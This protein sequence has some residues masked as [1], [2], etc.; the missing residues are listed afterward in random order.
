MMA[1][2]RIQVFIMVTPYLSPFM[3]PNSYK[4]APKSPIFLLHKGLLSDK[5]V[6]E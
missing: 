5:N 1:S 4:I 6:L 3:Y 2:D